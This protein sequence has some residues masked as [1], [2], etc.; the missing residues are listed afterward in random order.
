MASEKQL[1]KQILD[2]KKSPVGKL[3]ERRMRELEKNKDWFSELCFCI[4]TANASSKSGMRFQAK[5]RG[6]FHDASEKQLQKWLSES[7]CRFYRNKAKFI[8]EARS[9]LDS[10]K[11]KEILAAFEEEALAREWLVQNVKGLGFKEASHFMRNVGFKNL[12]IV[13]RHVLRVLK[14]HGLV[15]EVKMTP[16]KYLQVERKIASLC[17]KTGLTQGELDFYLWFMKTGKILK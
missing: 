14:E 12:A 17:R 15:G 10:K 4:S 1:V 13:D 16:K 9:K 8:V 6:K 5:G 2:L 3:V 11:L 7:G